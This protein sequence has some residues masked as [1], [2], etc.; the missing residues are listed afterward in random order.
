MSREKLDSNIKLAFSE[1]YQDLDKLIYIANNA[2]V[3]NHVEIK[4]IEKKIK[5]NVKALEYMMISK[6]D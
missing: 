2:S 6:R 4:R 3:F 5:Q 1:I